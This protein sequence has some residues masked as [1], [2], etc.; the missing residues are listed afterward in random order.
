MLHEIHFHFFFLAP[1]GVNLH[2]QRE[3]LKSSQRPAA[4]LVG[5]K[6]WKTSRTSANRPWL[7]GTSECCQPKALV[8]K[9]RPFFF[10]YFIFFILCILGKFHSVERICIYGLPLFPFYQLFNK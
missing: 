10:Y 1:S 2:G 8:D 3:T 9:F 5:V 4:P 7:R 6:S